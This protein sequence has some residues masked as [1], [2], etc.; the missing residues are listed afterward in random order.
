MTLYEYTIRLLQRLLRFDKIMNKLHTKIKLPM[1]WHPKPRHVTL[2]LA[3]FLDLIIVEKINFS[4][5]NEELS[6]V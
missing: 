6:N 1:G 3:L 2:D 5:L 4:L